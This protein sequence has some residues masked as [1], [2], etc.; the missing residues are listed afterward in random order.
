MLSEVVVIG[1]GSRV[2]VGKRPAPASVFFMEFVRSF[3]LL[4]MR[5]LITVRHEDGILGTSRSQLDRTFALGIAEDEHA[6]WN[7]VLPEVEKTPELFK[8][9]DD[10]ADVTRSDTQGFCTNHGILRSNDGIL[11]A[12]MQ[13][14]QTR[15]L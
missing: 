7:C 1:K 15:F 13:I 8:I 9:L 11:H 4:D 2:L 3:Q 5:L 12:K 6:G 14:S 10:I